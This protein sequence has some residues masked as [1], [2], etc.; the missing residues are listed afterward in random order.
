VAEY[1]GI[2]NKTVVATETVYGTETAGTHKLCIVSQDGDK[3]F[4]PVLLEGLCGNA[5]QCLPEQGTAAVNNTFTFDWLYDL[6]HPVLRAAFGGFIDNPTVGELDYYTFANSLDAIGFTYAEH[7]DPIETR[8][9]IGNKVNSVTLSGTPGAPMRWQ[10]ETLPTDMITPSIVNTPSTI[11]A[12]VAG[13]HPVVMYHHMKGKFW[14]GDMTDP[15]TI[16]DRVRPSSWELTW[17]RSQEAVYSDEQEPGEAT[18][19]GFTTLTL[20]IEIPRYTTAQYSAWHRNHTPLQILTEW[21]LGT[22]RR[23]IPIPGAIVTSAPTGTSGPGSQPQQ[24]VFTIGK[25]CQGLNANAG[26]VFNEVIRL[27]ETNVPVV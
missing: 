20:T 8:A 16:A 23:V 15:L 12:V 19:N 1:V 18:I 7:R 17:D 22:R 9:F 21:S 3:V 27:G 26:M 10:I 11:A 14:V 24:V 5:V 2:N 13:N 4:N 6:A 25:D